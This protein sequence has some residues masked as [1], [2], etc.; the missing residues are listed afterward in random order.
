MQTM[1]PSQK[2][3]IND[4]GV[5]LGVPVSGQSSGQELKITF[6]GDQALLNKQKKIKG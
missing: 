2:D 4:P 3:T 5:S 6:V 1:S